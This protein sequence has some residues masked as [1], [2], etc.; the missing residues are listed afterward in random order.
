MTDYSD[1]LRIPHLDTNVANPE[2]PENTAKDVID[3][4]VSGKYVHDMTSDENYT[5][6]HTDSPITPSDWQ[7]FMIEITDTTLVLTQS[8]NIFL[9]SNQRVYILINSTQESLGFGVVG[10]GVELVPAGGNMYAFSNGIDIIKLQ[11]IPSGVG[12]TFVS[13]S[14][15]PSTLTGSGGKSVLVSDDETHLEFAEPN[16]SFVNL[17][18][19]PVTYSG[20]AGLIPIVNVT[21]D[22]L[23]FG[24]VNNKYI[25]P[26]IP[27]LPTHGEDWL[28]SST[29]YEY[30]YYDTNGKPLASDFDSAVRSLNPVFYYKMN[31]TL[32]A[33]VMADQMGNYPGT[34]INSP[35]QGQSGLIVADPDT[36][37]LFDYNINSHA[38][39]PVSIADPL[40]DPGSPFSVVFMIKSPVYN[41][42]NFNY[43]ITIP[44]GVGLDTFSIFHSTDRGSLIVGGGATWGTY[45]NN[46]EFTGGT[47][48]VSVTY[49]GTGVTASSF[50][51]QINS[52]KASVSANNQTDTQ[53]TTDIVYISHGVN[54]V[55][56]IDATLDEVSFY[57]YALSESEI[58]ELY[59]LSLNLPRT[60]SAQWIQKDTGYFGQRNTATDNIDFP[61]PIVLDEE[62]VDD[63]GLTWSCSN[64]SPPVW[65]RKLVGSHSDLS[66]TDSADQH[67]IGAITDLQTELDDKEP[68]LGTPSEDGYIL[69][70]DQAKIRTWIP[71]DSLGGGGLDKIISSDI[72][73][74]PEHGQDWLDSSSGYEYTW[75]D[76][77]GGTGAT[78]YES[79]ALALN[80]LMYYRVD[81]TGG[82]V[83]LDAMGN[84]DGEYIGTSVVVNQQGLLLGDANTC[85]GTTGQQSGMTITGLPNN[86]FTTSAPFSVS[87]LINEET[88]NLSNGDLIF[89]VNNGTHEIGMRRTY[90]KQNIQFA[91]SSASGFAEFESSFET[92]VNT[93]YHVTLVFDGN[94]NTDLG[95]F[96][97]YINGISDSI[98]SINTSIPS[99]PAN[100]MSFR[101]MDGQN[102]N[103]IG[104]TDEIL[105]FD[106]E[107]SGSEVGSLYSASQGDISGQWLQKD[108]GYKDQ[109]TDGGYPQ[110]NFPNPTIVGDTFTD[111]KGV[112]WFA[113]NVVPAVWARSSTGGARIFPEL[114]DVPD[115]YVGSAN[116]LVSVNSSGNGLVFSD[117]IPE[118]YIQPDIPFSAIDGQDWLQDNTGTEFTF[119]AVDGGT[120]TDISDYQIDINYWPFPDGRIRINDFKFSIDGT[121]CYTIQEQYDVTTAYD[122]STM[123]YTGDATNLEYTNYALYFKPDGLEVSILTQD[124]ATTYIQTSTLAVAWD[125]TTKTAAF[126]TQ[127]VSSDI[128]N[129]TIVR[130]LIFKPDGTKMFIASD[131]SGDTRVHTWNLSVAWDVSTLSYQGYYQETAQADIKNLEFEPNGNK[132]YLIGNS[133]DAVHEY[134][135]SS[136]WDPSTASLTGTFSITDIASV[137]TTFNFSDDPKL[138]FIFG[139]TNNSMHRIDLSTGYDINTAEYIAKEFD[140]TQSGDA[141]TQFNSEGTVFFTSSSDTSGALEGSIKQYGMTSNWELSTAS[142]SSKEFITG[143]SGIKDIFVDSNGINMFTL[144]GSSNVRYFTMSIPW[145]L[146]TA[147]DANVLFSDVTNMPSTSGLHFSND[148]LIL[149]LSY[150]Y[151][152]AKYALSISGDITTASFIESVTLPFHCD[153][154]DFSSEGTIM[155]SQEETNL[156]QY[157]L[158]SSYDISS[159]ALYDTYVITTFTSPENIFLRKDNQD[160]FITRNGGDIFYY[161]GDPQNWS[162][163]WIAKNGQDTSLRFP[164]INPRIEFPDIPV[165]G[166]EYTDANGTIWVATNSL[167]NVWVE[168]GS[169]GSGSSSFAGLTDTPNDYIGS[170]GLS[171]VV[172]QTED[173][174]EFST[175]NGDKN[176]DGGSASSTYL[177]SQN[178]NGGDANG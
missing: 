37:T 47:N 105:W 163:N 118:K 22:A 87:M 175:A 117:S 50:T 89:A 42:N 121:K 145:D 84:Y 102:R 142:Y 59:R 10:R 108:S 2:V 176:I 71:A 64:V 25:Q 14:D 164:N 90:N 1:N 115:S 138:A 149:L 112:E 66:D 134:T 11:F 127:D 51:I 130:G 167:P 160:F 95:S 162:G 155:Y 161:F 171:A 57:N 174:I 79:V 52:T 132:F 111:S 73:I 77:G 65:N 169:G 35:V 6:I 30:T 15:T 58:D 31:E 86:I 68:D 34:Y 100:T 5:V 36:A 135:M 23:E 9:P 76:E 116:K 148:G 157:D 129:A 147:Q 166:D 128:S 3:Q 156:R 154:M 170:A 80:P 17:T 114:Q 72:P 29:G 168:K 19:T 178:V 70:S 48:F 94:N 7:N 140:G 109:I 24:V 151:D 33:T 82:T 101:G 61:R 21:E 38:E 81:E 110:I 120:P 137:S 20:Q 92:V 32:G 104:R 4:L 69:S 141:S 123:V 53:A 93:T 172:N 74:N 78:D 103:A 49:D 153:T 133:P 85:F 55:N 144:D 97:L 99:L 119:L 122:L 152:L 91:G 60:D 150:Q 75:Y 18:D 126:N 62:F 13:L 41:P 165:V 177:P 44:S 43:I 159:I 26:T 124:G 143:Y 173:G 98:V 113:S 8:R 67:P 139:W 136:A 131:F 27:P 39:I 88:F 83:A 146:D 12:S 46:D 54:G 56:G 96:K 45:S 40:V 158:S 28:Q 106:R 63:N 107:L 16:T 125:M